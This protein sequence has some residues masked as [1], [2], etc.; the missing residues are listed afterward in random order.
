LCFGACGGGSVPKR[1]SAEYAKVVSAFYI[2]LGALQVGDD[3][4]AEKNLSDVTQ[5]ASGEPAGWAN[6]GVLALRQ[7][8]L[9]DAALRME[10]ARKLAPD[11]DRI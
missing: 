1:D 11:N 4:H 7:R 8:K 5:M 2:G 3:I 10:R 6:W 9:D